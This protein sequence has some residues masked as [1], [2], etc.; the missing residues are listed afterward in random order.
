MG[1]RPRRARSVHPPISIR[2]PI[3]NTALCASAVEPAVSRAPRVRGRRVESADW[4]LRKHLRPQ[5]NRRYRA[6]ANQWRRQGG[7]HRLE[8]GDSRDAD[9]S[10]SRTQPPSI[11][12]GGE[13]DLL[14]LHPRDLSLSRRLPGAFKCG[15]VC[16]L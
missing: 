9:A 10:P 7:V 4:L 11:L 6:G 15:G 14:R 13:R 2:Y 3:Q 12:G 8:D 16:S 1:F 5:S